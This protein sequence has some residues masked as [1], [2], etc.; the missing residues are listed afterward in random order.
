[1]S[2]VSFCILDG[3]ELVLL[4]CLMRFQYSVMQGHLRLLE[5]GRR[6]LIILVRPYTDITIYITTYICRFYLACIRWVV[7]NNL[8]NEIANLNSFRS[9]T[10]HFPGNNYVNKR[11]FFR[12][13]LIVENCMRTALKND[14]KIGSKLKMSYMAH[15]PRKGNTK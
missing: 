2:N 8:I 11:T 12:V 10:I 9:W 13:F 4:I 14:E 5:R 15:F 3:Q 6:P 7:Q 1:M